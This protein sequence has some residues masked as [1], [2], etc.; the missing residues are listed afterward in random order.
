MQCWVREGCRRSLVSGVFLAFVAIFPAA[1]HAQPLQGDLNGDGVIDADDEDLLRPLY[2]SQSGD[3][4]YDPV[5]DA[6]GNGWIDVYDLAGFGT[7]FG[8]VGGEVDTTPPDLFVTLNDIPDDMNDLL[9]APPDGFHVTVD[10]SSAGGSLVDTASFS[11]TSSQDV[12]GLV[13]GSELVGLFNTTPTRATWVVPAGTNLNEASHYLTVSIDD[14]AGNTAGEIYGFAVRAFG[15][16]AP[17]EN[18]QRVFLD[19]DQDRSLGPEIDFLEDLREYGLSSTQD[20]T[21]EALMRDNVVGLILSDVHGYFERNAD[22]SAGPDSVNIQFFDTAPAEIHSRMCVGGESSQGAL[23]LGSSSLDVG[24]LNPGEDD[25]AGAGAT[26]GVFP[27][28]IDNLFAG[29]ANYQTIFGAIDSDLGGIPVGESPLD[30]IVLAPGFDL[31]TATSE[32]TLRFW[33][34]LNASAFFARTVATV[35]AHETG[36]LV[37]LVAHGPT[38]AGLFGGST[39]AKTD[40]NVTAT[41]G[42]PSENFLMNAGSSFSFEEMTGL[43]GVPLPVFRPLALAYLKGRI[44]LSASVTEL[45][46]PPQILSVSPNPVVYSGQNAVITFH[47][48][49]FVATPDIEL[50][51]E[52]DPTPNSVTNVTFVDAQTVTGTIN[53][54]AV[55]A[56]YFYDVRFGNPDGQVAWLIDG[57]EVQ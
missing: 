12:G 56:G 32:E 40:H 30:A 17:L 7:V 15:T 54:F 53:K 11:V 9:V 47:G 13:A 24:N 25:C 51:R 6:D 36:H 49:D 39:G 34:I 42:T 45:L 4:L 46:P 14:F 37:G 22:G 31:G 48:N 52:G 18:L 1:V 21:L 50:I 26:N 35:V 55:P 44:A 33:K 41:G 8:A 28:A 20:P 16:G 23:Y 5:A 38:P 57:L 3:A 10:F 43:T 27:Q 19:F 29:N 2:G